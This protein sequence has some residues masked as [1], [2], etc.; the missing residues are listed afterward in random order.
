MVAVRTNSSG[1]RID[2]GSEATVNPT[3]PAPLPTVW[4]GWTNE[5]ANRQTVWRNEKAKSQ[6]V[7]GKKG[8]DKLSGAWTS[9]N[10]SSIVVDWAS[11]DNLQ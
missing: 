6:K 5:K 9:N 11:A 1:A 8:T 7:W 2:G 3:H 4:S 10:R